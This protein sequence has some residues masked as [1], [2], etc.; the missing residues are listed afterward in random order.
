GPLSLSPDHREELQLADK[1][2]RAQ[3]LQVKME[4]G[5]H[6][7]TLAVGVAGYHT[8]LGGF[9]ETAKAYLPST[10]SDGLVFGTLSIPLSDWW[11]GIHAIKRQK[12]KLQQ[13]KNDR[14]NA[15]QMLQIDIQRAWTNL[16]EAYKQTQ[17][18]QASCDEAAENLRMT[19]DQYRMSTCT[20]TDLLDAETLNRR[21]QNDLAGAKA[22]YQTALA[23]YRR[24][25][26]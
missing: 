7:P 22:A 24:K 16:Q 18:A 25:A 12:I 11:D 3:Q 1:A 6:M 20:L 15:R 23:D 2:V 5:K 21:A 9:S 19:T 26:F 10:L 4:R 14:E 8:G 17:I 13:A